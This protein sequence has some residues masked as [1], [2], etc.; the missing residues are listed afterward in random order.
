MNLLETDKAYLAGLIDGEGCITITKAKRPHSTPLPIY[1]LLI[2]ISQKD[3]QLL[4]FWKAKTQLGSVFAVKKS[5]NDG[6]YQWQIKSRQAETL[7]RAV[8]DFLIL[9]KNQA[10][11]VFK[12]MKA[13]HKRGYNKRSSSENVRFKEECYQSIKKLHDTN[14]DDH[15]NAI[16]ISKSNQLYLL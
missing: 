2:V 15:Q 7:L 14:E 10:D 16:V 13:T 4:D 5:R 6:I 12:F 8:Y 9:K 11:L 1:I 3:K